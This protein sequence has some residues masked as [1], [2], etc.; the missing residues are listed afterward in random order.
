MSRRIAA[1]AAALA[2]ALLPLHAAA[3]AAPPSPAQVLGYELGE[4]FTP[5]SGVQQYARALAAA[6]PDRVRYLPYGETYEGRELFQLVFARPD[7]MARLDQVLAAN[8][9]LARP[10]TGAGRAAQVA[11]ENPAVVYFSYGVHGNESSSSEAAMWTAWDLARGA[12][13][14]PDVIDAHPGAD[15]ARAS[16]ARPH[17]GVGVDLVGGDRVAQLQ[18][19]HRQHV[20]RH[21]PA[22][23]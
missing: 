15:L 2:L 10:E 7:V 20:G 8:A 4:R 21:S 12:P 6:A 1:G 3:Q 22:P 17:G 23:S 11:A 18:R 16:E 5:Y 13:E 14:V 9:E 19:G